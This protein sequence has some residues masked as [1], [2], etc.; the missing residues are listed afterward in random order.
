M[1][2]RWESLR[3]SALVMGTLA[4]LVGP[5]AA[6]EADAQEADAKRPDDESQA[7]V[8]RALK[9]MQAFETHIAEAKDATDP[10]GVAKP[11]EKEVVDLIDRPLLTYGDPARVNENG[12][13]WAFGKVGRPMAFVE[14]FRGAEGTPRSAVWGHCLTLTAEHRVIMTT[15]RETPW[16]PESIQIA[17][18]PIPEA[19][20]PHS[21]ETVRSRQMKEL[22][23]RFTA[24]EF[25][26]P[27][28]SRFELRLLQQPVLRYGD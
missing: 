10:T 23:R 19:A 15:P 7:R 14:L 25:W 24:H 18:A 17:P 22:A 4:A 16:T 3:V 12:T 5:L 28:N 6:R 2:R 27:E 20:A 11:K 21:K 8:R 26:N 1:S 9:H 13:L